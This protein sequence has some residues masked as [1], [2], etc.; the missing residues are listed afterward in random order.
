MEHLQSEFFEC[1]CSSDEHTLKFTFNTEEKE[2]YTLVYLHQYHKFW[3]R[4]WIAI[5]YVF[6]YKC[7][8]GHW[9]CFVMKYKDVDRMK[10]LLEEYNKE[11][12]TFETYD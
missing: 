1:E 2:I 9:D 10:Q 3:E 8:Y 7:K 11:E 5:K 12:S 6:G 4:I